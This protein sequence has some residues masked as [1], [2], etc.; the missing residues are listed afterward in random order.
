[1][2]EVLIIDHTKMPVDE[3]TGD[4]WML[5]VVDQF[6]KF[7]WVNPSAQADTESATKF[8][9]S[10]YESGICHNLKA[11]QADNGKAFISKLITAL[12]NA[13]KVMLKHP[14]TYNPRPNGLVE[15]EHAILKD[16]VAPLADRHREATGDTRT[17]WVRFISITVAAR[18]RR[19]RRSLDQ[20]CSPFFL[21]FRRPPNAIEE[22]DEMQFQDEPFWDEVY[23]RTA[24]RQAAMQRRRDLKHNEEVA[25]T[26]L[27]FTVGE[28]CWFSLDNANGKKKKKDLS[29]KFP[30]R[31]VVTQVNST[32]PW[33]VKVRYYE[34][35]KRPNV[36][37]WVDSDVCLAKRAQSVEERMEHEAV[38]NV[39]KTETTTSVYYP[40]FQ[41]GIPV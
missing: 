7:T 37:D 33:K 31:A 30:F 6:S 21:V 14:R 22:P 18:N 5:T 26:S 19:P 8:I 4:E 24:E 17:M 32:V 13:L 39:Q 3:E 36:S 12:T 38:E 41:T 35:G 27:M 16:S 11:I 20:R 10:I 28:A 2:G 15:H 9:L 1:M 34:A 23:S 40:R 29:L 25:L